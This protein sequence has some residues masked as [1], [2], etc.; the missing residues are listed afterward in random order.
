MR[1]SARSVSVVMLA[2]VAMASACSPAPESQGAPPTGTPFPA[3]QIDA[4]PV[5]VDKMP[6][7][8]ETV[9]RD[10]QPETEQKPQPSASAPDGPCGLLDVGF[11]DVAVFGGDPLAFR[12]LR[13][14]GFSNVYVGQA[15]GVY[16]DVATAETVFKKLVDGANDCKAAGGDTSV[17]TLEPAALAWQR[18]WGTND[19]G[20]TML[21]D[22]ARLVQNVVVRV[23]VAQFEQSPQIAAGIT[24]QIA[25]KIANPA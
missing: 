25:A 16:P 24:D 7:V 3:G 6:L 1:L 21:A 15:V 13:N 5:P 22:Q 8:G 20:P 18:S 14:S 19:A 4:L 17:T 9:H 10:G 11:N 2:A 23:V 12:S